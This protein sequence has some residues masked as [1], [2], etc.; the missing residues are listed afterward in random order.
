MPPEREGIVAAVQTPLGFFS[1]VVLVLEAMLGGLAFA[2]AGTERQLLGYL[3]A[4]ILGALVLL[5]ASLAAFRPEALW[6][7]RYNSLTRQFAQRLGVE[8]FEALDGYL[9]NL[10]AENRQ[11]AYQVLRGSILSCADESDPESTA[12]CEAFVG[13][14]V[15]RAKIRGIRP[16]TRV[17]TV[18]PGKSTSVGH[19]T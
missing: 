16:T 2:S 19:G 9:A 5:V 15:K 7:K 6:G 17:L 14:I 11:E 3:A 8:V 18:R 10:E 4:G 1:L 13:T 12:F